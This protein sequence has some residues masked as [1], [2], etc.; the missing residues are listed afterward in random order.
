M[1][2]AFFCSKDNAS[3]TTLSDEKDENLINMFTIAVSSVLIDSSVSRDVFESGIF[4]V[5][6]HSQWT[7]MPALEHIFWGDNEALVRNTYT[8]TQRWAVF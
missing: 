2:G 5:V 8:L 6:L 4:L 3:L 7:S 1:H